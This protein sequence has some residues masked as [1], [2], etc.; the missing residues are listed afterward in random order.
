MTQQRS[1]HSSLFPVVDQPRNARQLLQDSLHNVQDIKGNRNY[2]ILS[3]RFGFFRYMSFLI[4]TG[5]NV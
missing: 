5:F 4:W 2:A 1:A 3:E